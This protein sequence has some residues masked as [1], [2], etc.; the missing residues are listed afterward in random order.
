MNDDGFSSLRIEK[1]RTSRFCYHFGFS[2]AWVV[3]TKF[4]TERCGDKQNSHCTRAEFRNSK[5]SRPLDFQK[6][7]NDEHWGVHYSAKKTPRPK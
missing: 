7:Q 4:S 5:S 3:L 2:V 1:K 6:C